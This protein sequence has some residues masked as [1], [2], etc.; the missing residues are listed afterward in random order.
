MLDKSI[1]PIAV[2]T[3]GASGIGL[4]TVELLVAKGY[5]VYIADIDNDKGTLCE[6]KFGE[7]VKHVPCDVTSE[8]DFANLGE[9]IS[10]EC[11]RLNV[12]IN[13][14]GVTGAMG[15]IT[16]LSVNDFEWIND[17]LVRSVF[18]GTRCAA[19]IMKPQG[20][21]RIVNIGSMA[22]LTAGHSPHLYAGAKAAV[23]HFSE[24]VALELA[25]S[26]VQLN[27]VCPGYIKTPIITGTKDERWIAR[28]EKISVELSQF[29]A[30]GRIGDPNEVASA[31]C[32]LACDAP[33]FVVGHSLVVD[34]GCTV[35]RTWRSQP[36]HFRTYHGSAS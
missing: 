6:T 33:D 4:A 19:T 27:I 9:L 26:G 23:I 14:A 17:V 36:D 10:T 35:G 1:A 25:E 30:S 34:G 29:Q 31:V 20:F 5:F 16:E 24:S 15:P 13:N 12:F 22:G 3:G 8:V 28:A 7:A 18:L 21:G 32:W 2:V 11:G